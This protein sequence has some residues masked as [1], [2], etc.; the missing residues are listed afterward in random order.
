MAVQ[1]ELVSLILGQSLQ[2]GIGDSGFQGPTIGVY[3]AMG[4]PFTRVFFAVGD[5]SGYLCIR[6]P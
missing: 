4:D 6:M 2:V 1:Q 3:H 5:K